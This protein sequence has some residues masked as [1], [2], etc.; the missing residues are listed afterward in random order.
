MHEG[1]D[2]WFCNSKCER[3]FKFYD[4]RNNFFRCKR[5][6]VIT[7]ERCRR[8]G[9]HTGPCL[10]STR[11]EISY[12]K[13]GTAQSRAER[14]KAAVHHH[15]VV[16]GE[17]TGAV[18]QFDAIF[19]KISDDQLRSVLGHSL[20]KEKES[21]M[22]K[23]NKKICVVCEKRLT[24]DHPHAIFCS[25]DCG[26]RAA[27]SLLAIRLLQPVADRAL[28]FLAGLNLQDHTIKEQREQIEI[29]N[30]LVNTLRPKRG[31]L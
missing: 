14:I 18:D 23:N 16:P 21:T 30:Q 26:Q 10:F 20:K 29:T 22:P 4:T 15:V 19:T 28:R 25:G 2:I 17:F 24:Q 9:G 3:Y 31:K 6:G 11:N 13:E 27:N 5:H 1:G 8:E 12:D 7:E